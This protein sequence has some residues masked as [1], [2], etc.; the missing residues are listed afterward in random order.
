MGSNTE[1]KPEPIYKT[2]TKIEARATTLLSQSWKSDNFI[3]SKREKS[4]IA[5]AILD[6]WRIWTYPISPF[7]NSLLFLTFNIYF[8]IKHWQQIRS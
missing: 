5:I 8:V 2:Y 1:K 3:G 4:N 6:K 7:K